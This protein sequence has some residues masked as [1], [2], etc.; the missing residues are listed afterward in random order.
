MINGTRLGRTMPT[1][2][3]KIQKFKNENSNRGSFLPFW[4]S[5][6]HLGN[7]YWIWQKMFKKR[8]KIHHSSRSVFQIERSKNLYHSE[9]HK[10]PFLC[11]SKASS[12]FLPSGNSWLLKCFKSQHHR[13]PL[14]KPWNVLRWPW[15]YQ[16]YTTNENIYS[17]SHNIAKPMTRTA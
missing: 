10:V 11:I 17:Y 8:P 2:R 16:R 1:K 4:Q 5:L 6:D 9:T 7:F 14:Q 3:Q 15:E 12:D 13:W